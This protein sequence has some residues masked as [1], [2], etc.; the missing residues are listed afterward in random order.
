MFM[1][2]K[3]NGAS[4][5][6]CPY[7]FCWAQ[8]RQFPWLF[9]PLLEAIR[10]LENKRRMANL[11]DK[12]FRCLLPIE[13]VTRGFDFTRQRTN[14]ET[15]I[16]AAQREDDD[17]LHRVS[18]LLRDIESQPGIKNENGRR[19]Y[20][21]TDLED[22]PLDELQQFPDDAMSI[23]PDGVPKPMSSSTMHSENEE[24]IVSLPNQDTVTGI[25]Y[26]DIRASISVR[27]SQSQWMTIVMWFFCLQFLALVIIAFLFLALD[28]EKPSYLLKGSVFSV[29]IV[30]PLNCFIAV[31]LGLYIGDGRASKFQLTLLCILLFIFLLG[32]SVVTVLPF[33][34]GLFIWY[35]AFA[36]L[37]I[38]VIQF[39]CL[40]FR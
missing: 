17:V 33:M 18:S 16:M 11:S 30:Q 14:S 5:R 8:S 20:S 28:F 23:K 27:F 25:G 31:A 9:S 6:S 35:Y 39:V 1:A 15:D 3:M 36:P 24:G 2:R 13:M 21:Q 4:D 34:S 40:N 29:F 10:D 22:I 7:F 26:V 37:L 32:W 38:T 12:Q 19:L